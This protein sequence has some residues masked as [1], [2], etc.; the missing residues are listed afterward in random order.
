M[1]T[2]TRFAGYCVKCASWRP[3]YAEADDFNQFMG[4]V[5]GCSEEPA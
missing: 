2:D 3:D 1:S 4:C 5:C